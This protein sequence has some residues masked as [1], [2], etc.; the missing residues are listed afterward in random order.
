M[1][2]LMPRQMAAQCLTL[3]YG[4]MEQLRKILPILVQVTIPLPLRMPMD[5]LQ[6]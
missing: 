1:E 4:A 6:L 5:V 2:V 3:I